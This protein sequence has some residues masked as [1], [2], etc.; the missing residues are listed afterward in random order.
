MNWFAVTM[1]IIDARAIHRRPVHRRQSALDRRS[2]ALSKIF[3][4][5]TP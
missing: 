3:P 5:I 2:S 4:G 1:A